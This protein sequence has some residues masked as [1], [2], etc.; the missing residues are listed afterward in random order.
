MRILLK[1]LQP[2][3]YDP[4]RL[5]GSPPR[6]ALYRISLGD[7]GRLL[8]AITTADFGGLVLEA[9][10]VGHSSDWLTPHL[11]ALAQQ[12]PVVLASR[13][14]AGEVHSATYGFH[15]SETDL[16]QR[17]LLNARRLDGLKA[18]LLLQVHLWSGTVA[19]ELS[20]AFEHWSS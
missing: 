18:R 13:T 3:R 8:H 9:F 4:A 16:L 2:P 15:G 11:Q 7:D 6:V 19:T 10:G 17:G 1:P 5:D 12:M 20:S 14:G